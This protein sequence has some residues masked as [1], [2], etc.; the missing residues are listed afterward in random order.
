[1]TSLESAVG[2][3]FAFGL[4]DCKAAGWD[5]NK[6]M[7]AR[8]PARPLRL[9]IDQ[10]CLEILPEAIGLSD[11]FGFSDWELDRWAAFLTDCLFDSF[12]EVPL[13]CTTEGFMMRFGNV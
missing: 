7:V 4:L 5:G 3:L 2:D 12:H 6:M 1:M 8:D 13:A 9:T 11:A 10:L